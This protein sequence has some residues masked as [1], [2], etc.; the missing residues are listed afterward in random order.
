MFVMLTVTSKTEGSGLHGGYQRVSHTEVGDLLVIVDER[1]V[2]VALESGHS[3]PLSGGSGRNSVREE[4]MKVLLRLLHPE[5]T[6]T[7]PAGDGYVMEAMPTTKAA[8]A[9]VVLF[10]LGQLADFESAALEEAAAAAKA[11]LVDGAA[12]CSEWLGRYRRKK[13]TFK[14]AFRKEGAYELKAYEA[15][16]AYVNAL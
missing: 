13:D 10:C 6:V 12:L 1:G 14:S 7:V 16:A 2:R 5:G 3:V 4:R 9:E 15:Y 11:A 8:P